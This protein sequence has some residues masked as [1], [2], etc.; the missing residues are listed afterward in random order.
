MS[1]CMTRWISSV[2]ALWLE[3]NCVGSRHRHIGGTNRRPMFDRAIIAARCC[4]R[5][6]PLFCAA[7]TDDTEVV[8]RTRSLQLNVAI[9]RAIVEPVQ[10]ALVFFWWHHLLACNIDS[11]ADWN[12]QECMQR[13]RTQRACQ[14]EHGWQ[15][16]S[17]VPGDRGIDLHRH[18]ELLQVAHAVDGGFERSRDPAESVVGQR[19]GA[20]Q[21]DGNPLHAC[22]DDL[23]RYRFR[24]QRT[25]RG[26]GDA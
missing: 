6:L 7:L 21:A 14:V 10:H 26:Q 23:L 2:I 8:R 3:D 18:A 24:N 17:I 20:I 1:T 22:L 19:I 16:V 12:Q 13:I 9:L 25:V 11:A 5:F 4:R 15:L